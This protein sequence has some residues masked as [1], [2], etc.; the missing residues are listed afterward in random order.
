MTFASY[1][2]MLSVMKVIVDFL[3][4]LFAAESYCLMKVGE[5]LL[6]LSLDSNTFLVSHFFIDSSIKQEC[7]FSIR[8]FGRK[9]FLYC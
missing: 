9:C 1:T 6:G 7:S 3:G 5:D 4:S 2:T 8:I